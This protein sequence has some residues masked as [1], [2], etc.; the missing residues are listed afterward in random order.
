MI[1]E[2]VSLQD[3]Q[4]ELSS[5]DTELDRLSEFEDSLKESIDTRDA[6]AIKQ[7]NWL[8]RQRQE[9]IKYLLMEAIVQLEERLALWDRFSQR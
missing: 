6:K 7:R 3:Y 4:K 5:I 2:F 9:D 1:V 8:L